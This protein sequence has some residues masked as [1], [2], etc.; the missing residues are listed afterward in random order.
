MRGNVHG[1]CK[2]VKGAGTDERRRKEKNGRLLGLG[3]EV[4]IE[5]Q[6]DD[7]H[8]ISEDFLFSD[9]PHTTIALPPTQNLLR[10]HSVL[11][12]PS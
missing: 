7:D 3:G 9:F 8:S 11:F 1:I 2:R 4:A 10:S 6:V 5:E 12:P